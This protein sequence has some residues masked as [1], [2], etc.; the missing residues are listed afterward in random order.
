VIRS[1]LRYRWRSWLTLA[2]L[3]AVV[4]GVVLGATAA[5]RRTASAFPRYDAAHGYD[6]YVYAYQPLPKLSSLPEVAWSL[7]ARGPANG[8]PQCA[9]THPLSAID[10][11][12]L[13]APWPQASRLFKLVSGR[14]PAADAPD[15]VLASYTF[16]RD[17]GI[18]VG[19]VVRVPFYSSS[20]LPSVIDNDAGEPAGPTAALKV[21]GIEAGETDFPTVGTISYTLMTSPAFDRVYGSRI[22]AFRAYAV[23]LRHGEAQ[24]PRFEQDVL[25]IGGVG[26]SD[27]D[28]SKASIEAAIHPQAVG[29]WVLA[30]LA[31]LAALAVVGQALSRQ[32][33]VEAGEYRTLSAVG[34]GPTDLLVLGLARTVLIGITGALGAVALA[35]ALSPIAPVGEARVAEPST[36]FQF[37]PLVLGLGALGVV[38]VVVALGLW[39]AYRASGPVR[40][41]SARPDRPSKIV[42]SLAAA[43][44]PVSAVIGIRRALDRGRGRE[45]IP[46]GS[47]LGGAILAVAALAGTAVF[48]ASLTHLVSTPRLYGQDF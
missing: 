12:I 17:E 43:G 8:T 41:A 23:K 30:L 39:P 7:P 45:S 37:D 24:A 13:D 11:G 47:A 19:S 26:T 32:S 28:L 36:G 4:G 20:Q 6:V 31:A 10:I 2:L 27:V 35:F 38:L 14:L 3:V 18:H 48:G 21:V 9:C 1:E 40:D 15:E 16:Q 22:G 42:T 46:V 5:G 33:N 44:A 29:W 25:A 34:M